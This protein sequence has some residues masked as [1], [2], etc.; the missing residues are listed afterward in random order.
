[1]HTQL[2]APPR[3]TIIDTDLSFDDYVALLYLLQEPT[4]DIRAITVAN[5]VVH[6]KP[7]LENLR[8]LLALVERVDIPIAAG[9]DAPLT[10]NRSAPRLWRFL[11]DYGP[12]LLL[13]MKKAPPAKHSAPELIREQ[14]LA[15]EA[16]VTM[17]TFGPLTNLATSLREDPSL[18]A[19][20]E[21]IHV[22]GGA[23]HVPGAV[24]E[25]NPSNPN[26]VAE[27]NMYLDP[28]AAEIVFQATSEAAATEVVLLPMDVT[29]VHGD[30]PLLFS[31]EFID[32]LGHVAEGA[33]SKLLMKFVRVWHPVALRRYGV[34]PVWDAAAAV[35]AAH[36]EISQ[37]WRE[38]GIHIITEPDNV[39]GQTVIDEELPSNARLCLGA[40]QRAFEQ[41]F[42][43]AVGKGP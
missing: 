13:P 34:T 12:R 21:S 1:M 37:Q 6:V 41:I 23:V 38:V 27:W 19:H 33:A 32:R 29:H 24:H 35:L 30:Q 18:T 22:S 28:S 43:N 10:G 16:P 11:L 20:I 9:P 5:G 8:R 39:A 31:E 4:V 42:L 15:S 17:M 7:G 14:V 36:P 40:D 26:A 2:D 3:P 25:D